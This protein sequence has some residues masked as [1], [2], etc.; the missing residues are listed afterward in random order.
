ADS[1]LHEAQPY[2]AKA[3]EAAPLAFRW[4]AQGPDILFFYHPL[5]ENSINR[6]GHRMHEE[7]VDRMFQALTAACSHSHTPEAT[8]YLLGYCCHYILDRSAHPFVTYIANYR[9][10]PLYPQLS[11]SAQHNLCESELDRALIAAA[12]SGKPADYPAHMIL[13]YDNKTA[14]CIGTVL[15]HAIW[16]VYGTRVPVS[17]VKSSMRSMIHVQH[18]LHDRSGR[19]HTALSWLEHRLHISGDFSSLI[20]PLAPIDADCT[21]HSHQPWIDAS[22]PHM[23]RY[24][25]YFQILNNAQRPA[26]CLM[27]TCYDAVQTGKPLPKHLFGLN[28]MGMPE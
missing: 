8:A 15:S 1:A 22:M 23:R 9:I 4:G 18:L 21:N 28:Y 3:I 14:N 24:T 2:L 17:A 25:D 6:V 16:N 10:D 11:L 20:R 5:T 13:S 12:H 26:A 7:R 19:R 27:E